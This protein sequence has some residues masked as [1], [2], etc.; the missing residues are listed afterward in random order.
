MK[1]GMHIMAPEP[2]SMALLH[3]YLTLVC[4]PVCLPQLSLL[5]KG[6]V[7]C[8]PALVDRQWLGTQVPAATNTR[9]NGRIVGRVIF[10]AVRALSKKSLWVCLCI[11]LS[12][13]A[14]NSVKTFQL[15]RRIIGGIVFYKVR[16]VPKENK[17]LVLPR[18]SC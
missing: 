11:P 8:I 16:V 17:R 10:Y 9:N 3:K 12:L 18:T 14:N 2:I 7:K 13:S 15:Q 1:V 6:S 5:G 4:V